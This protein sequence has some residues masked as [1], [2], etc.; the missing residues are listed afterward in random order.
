[1]PRLSMWRDNH[2]N[3]YKFFDQRISETFTI[4]GTGILLHKYLGPTAQANAYVTT[5][6]TSANTRTLYFANV[7]TFEV[8]QSVSGIGIASNTAIFS[9]NVSANSITLTSN[10]TSTISS[11]QPVNIY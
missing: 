4:G 10:V 8:G 5:S 2:T 9:T 11:G 1:M 3:D 7:S 6:N